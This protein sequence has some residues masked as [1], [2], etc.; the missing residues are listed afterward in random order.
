MYENRSIPASR[1][2]TEAGFYG[3]IFSDRNINVT[4]ERLTSMALR[5]KL[6]SYAKKL[7]GVLPGKTEAPEKKDAP[8]KPKT[9]K[10]KKK[11]IYITRVCEATGWSREE[12]KEKMD[13]VK[14]QLGVPYKAYWEME[15]YNRTRSQQERRA[16]GYLREVE[17]EKRI[18]KRI[19]KESGQSPAKAR[20]RIRELNDLGLYKVNVSTYSKYGMYKMETEDIK[21]LLGI[22]S[23]I[24]RK[25][26]SLRAQLAQIDKGN[27]TYEDISEELA[28]YKEL[29]DRTITPDLK[30]KVI[31]NISAV[32]PDLVEDPARCHEMLVDIE[33]CRT[34]LHF[35]LGEYK[36]YHLYDADFAGKRDYVNDYDRVKIIKPLNTKEIFDL[37][38]NKYSLYQKIG[39]YFKRDIVSIVSKED[40]PVFADYVAKHPTFVCKPLNDSLGRGVSLE[41]VDPE[42][43]LEAQFSALLKDKM[44][45]LMEERIIPSEKMSVF[46]KDSLNTVRLIVWYDGENAIPVGSF[47]RT[48]RPGS[49]VDNAGAGGVFAS[50][51]YEKGVLNSCGADEKGRLYEEHP[52]SH[53]RYEGFEIP[54]WEGALKVGC[55]AIKAIGTSCFIGWDL[56]LN[57]NEEWVVV[58]GNGL[59][60]FVHQSP[61]LHGVKPRLMKDLG[62]A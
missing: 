1:S 36:M 24:S 22:L 32:R 51:D 26:T 49:F 11:N 14:K 7:T 37:V 47:F 41:T 56:A 55:E 57:E 23:Q 15:F 16:S 2:Y 21:D 10:Q 59:P 20:E 35:T 43:D 31:R 4:H 17:K 58:E 6:T 53:V 42:G 27:L 48:G 18:L 5:N 30:D 40:F 45:F 60:Q 38:N 52:D 62:K 25:T 9:V 19:R 29:L 8:D 13:I 46:N 12:A 34:L 50:V 28:A 3:I 61:L 54:N 39:E 44:T 33:L